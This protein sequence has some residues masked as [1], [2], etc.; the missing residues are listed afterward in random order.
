MVA[1]VILC[2]Y[3]IQNWEVSYYACQ[4]ELVDLPSVLYVPGGRKVTGNFPILI[5][6]NESDNCNEIP[7][8]RAAI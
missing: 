3:I 4:A 8:G 5:R 2:D 1:G 6:T 7:T